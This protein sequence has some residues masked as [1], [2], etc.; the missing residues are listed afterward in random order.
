MDQIDRF[1]LLG[2]CKVNE[3]SSI[4][5][6]KKSPDEE[7]MQKLTKIVNPGDPHT[8]YVLQEIIGKGGFGIVYKARNEHTKKMVG[9]KI[10]KLK[11]PVKEE[12]LNEVIVMRENRHPNLVNFLDSHVVED[13]L[14]IVMEFL[15]GG[16]L[17]DIIINTVMRER[18]IAVVCREIL[19]AIAFL[20][21]RGIIHCDIKSSNVVFGMDGSVKLI[22]FMTCKHIETV[23]K[24][25]SVMGTVYWMAPEIL[26]GIPY[27]TKVDIWSLGIVVTEMV[28]GELPFLSETYFFDYQWMQLTNKELRTKDNKTISLVLQDFLNECL[29]LNTDKRSSAENLLMHPFL[30]TDENISLIKNLIRL[31]KRKTR[32]R[33]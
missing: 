31:A 32:I 8:T 2:Q 19:Q 1:F 7:N 15:G 28:S 24:C 29:E 21:S 16:T 11:K 30:Q 4:K 18:Q 20:H 12:V 10:I 27:D 6:I 22:D 23:K 26:Y 17:C 9:I 25:L 13:N 3:H 5:C 33:N 14:W